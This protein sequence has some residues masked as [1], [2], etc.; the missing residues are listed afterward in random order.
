MKLSA[1]KIENYRSIQDT[2]FQDINNDGITAL[3]GQNE[4]GKSSILKALELFVSPENLTEDDLRDDSPLPII[5]CVFRLE[6]KE[7]SSIEESENT[8]IHEDIKKYIASQGNIIQLQRVWPNKNDLSET[9]VQLENKS[10]VTFFNDIEHSAIEEEGAPSAICDCNTFTQIIY[11]YSPNITLFDDS[12]ILP[13]TIDLVDLKSSKSIVGKRGALNFLKIVGLNV[14]TLTALVEGLE[15]TR[16]N[17]IERANAKISELL[18]SFWSQKLGISDVISLTMD[19]NVY[20][21]RVPTKTGTYYLS[22]WVKD[23]TGNVR[24]A[25][26]SAGVQWFVS[27]FLTLKSMPNTFDNLVLIDEPGVH[28]HAK[29]QGDILKLLESEKESM[30][31]IYSTHSPYLLDIERIN[32]I[33]I[34]ERLDEKNDIGAVTKVFRPQDI[35]SATYDSLLPL[36]SKMGISLS[37]QTVIKEKNNVLLEEISAYYYIKGFMK[38]LDKKFEA[39]FLPG[40]GCTKLPIMAN[41]L[42]GWGID[43]IVVLDDDSAGKYAAKELRLSSGLSDDRIINIT[44]AEGIEDIF[45]LEDFLKIANLE[46]PSKYSSNSALAKGLKKPLIASSFLDKIDNGE[47]TKETLSKETVTKMERLLKQIEEALKNRD[48]S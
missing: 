18:Q 43:F 28:L 22:F 19:I 5:T 46:K 31:I 12:T 20:D 4:S 45:T 10:M 6:K 34:V 7:L 23:G 30:Q 11:E 40:S 32:R 8:I 36:F 26:R 35:G 9:F 16:I 13:A 48:L 33:L 2:G 38:L 42:T 39:H 37:K 17:K 41:L 21:H 3:I 27:F 29:A 24:L 14:A 25:Q 15:K 1:F 47:I 44:K